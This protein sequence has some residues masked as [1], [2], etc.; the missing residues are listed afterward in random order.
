ERW[1]DEQWHG[2]QCHGERCKLQALRVYV[3]REEDAPAVMAACRRRFG[4]TLPIIPL[5]SAI[6][7][8][9]LL[10]EIEGVA[11]VPTPI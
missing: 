5:K 10:V 1:H 3:R 4:E 6:C 8:R 11:S 2:E 7:R 9:E